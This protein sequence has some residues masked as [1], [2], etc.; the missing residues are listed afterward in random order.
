M[1]HLLA[2]ANRMYSSWSL[3]GWL[4]FDKFGIPISIRH[5]SMATPAFPAML[6]EFSPARTVPA[7]RTGNA[8]VTD[9][10]AIAETLA[11]AYSDR[12]MWP[13]DPVR[14]GLARS[15]VAEIHSGFAPLRSD[16]AM[17]LHHRYPTFSPSQPVLEDLTRITLLWDRARQ[18]AAPGDWLF[19]AYSIADAFYAPVAARIAGHSLPVSGF[20]AEYVDRHINDLSFRR[21]RAMGVAEATAMSRYQLDLPTAPWP[22]PQPL[23]AK[24]AQQATPENDACPY[25]GKPVATDSIARFGDRTIGFCN[26]F[27]RDK[28]VADP[29]AWPALAEML[30]REARV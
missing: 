16:C 24:A 2:I 3:R 21:W 11:E 8:V 18:V 12:N 29:L 9:S 22:G 23:P 19:G 28:S 30:T 20:A 17:N 1:T 10:L 27:C 13:D 15:I 5:A 25:S 6:E 26:T 7:M 14:R 4:L